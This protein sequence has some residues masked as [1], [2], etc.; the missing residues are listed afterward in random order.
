MHHLVLS[1]HTLQVTC[2]ALVCILEERMVVGPLQIQCK[3]S[4]QALV[5]HE[6]L[7]GDLG[8]CRALSAESRHYRSALFTNGSS[9][10]IV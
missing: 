10:R 6:G 5:D 2:R 8:W 7:E 3:V 1:V 4:V 9:N